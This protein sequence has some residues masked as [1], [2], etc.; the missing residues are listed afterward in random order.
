MYFIPWGPFYDVIHATSVSERLL[1]LLMYV[2]YIV[3]C[4]T[5]TTAEYMSVMLIRPCKREIHYCM[6]M[7]S[8]FDE[9]AW[10]SISLYHNTAGSRSEGDKQGEVPTSTPDANEKSQQKMVC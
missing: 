7:Q 10:P 2:S 3:T 5:S 4:V 6:T 8:Y 1:F 9:C